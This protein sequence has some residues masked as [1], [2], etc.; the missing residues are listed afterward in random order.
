MKNEKI[1]NAIGKLSNDLIEDAAIT[2][3]TKKQRKA[4]AKWTMLAACLC[5]LIV[6]SSIIV[7]LF[8]SE[9]RINPL[10]ITVYARAE[11]GSISSTELKLGEKVKLYPAT[12]PHTDSFNGYAFDLTLLGAKYVSPCAVDENWEPKLYPGWSYQYTD[13]DFH[14]ALTEGSEILVVQVDKNGKVIQSDYISGPKPHGSAIIWRPND[15]GL[16]RN[17]IRAYDDNFQLI[18]TYYLEITEV[19][20]DYYAEIVKIV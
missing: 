12:S 6:A 18:A 15:D 19:N 13:D 5:L 1:L 16:N 7:P 17:I 2:S 14:W 4:W 9:P 20:G 11:D 8:I 3:K 10:V